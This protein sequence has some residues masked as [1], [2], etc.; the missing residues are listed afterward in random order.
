MRLL[1]FLFAVDGYCSTGGDDCGTRNTCHLDACL[2]EVGR[3]VSERA[4]VNLLLRDIICTEE[5]DV[6][7]CG[8]VCG[9]VGVRDDVVRDGRLECVVSDLLSRSLVGNDKRVV[10]N[11]HVCLF[12]DDGEL[13]LVGA[14]LVARRDGCLD[15]DRTGVD[16]LDRTGTVDRRDVVIAAV[17]CRARGRSDECAVLVVEHDGVGS[18]DE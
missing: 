1:A 3:V 13:Q 11:L 14:L 7:R 8:A 6:L 17:V 2:G 18:I 10:Y 16:S 4:A 5:L 9:V 12:L 15:G